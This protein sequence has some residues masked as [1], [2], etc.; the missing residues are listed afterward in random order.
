M[1]PLL[2]LILLL[3]IAFSSCKKEDANSVVT[4]TIDGKSWVSDRIVTSV[5]S[6]GDLTKIEASA[7]D[8]TRIVFK[9]TNTELSV[10]G[11]DF[12]EDDFGVSLASSLEFTATPSLHEITYQINLI[13]P[14]TQLTN[15][16]VLVSDD[17]VSFFPLESSFLESAPFAKTWVASNTRS[18][19]NDYQL[20]K[21]KIE[22]GAGLI[23][24][25]DVVL[26]LTSFRGQYDGG[27]LTTNEETG[28]FTIRTH[29]RANK[30]LT[31]DFRFSTAEAN[32]TLGTISDLQY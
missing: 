14:S 1:R 23:W 17:Q 24:E 16:E 11:A 13:S 26:G 18:S 19:N 28:D 9:I 21:V 2:F 27:A 20:F 3:S 6:D 22:Y 7:A 4:A 12:P 29:D 31:V 10:L 5:N 15:L 8:N 32:I 30:K 25:S